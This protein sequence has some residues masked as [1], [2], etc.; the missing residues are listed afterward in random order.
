MCTVSLYG[1]FS[2]IRYTCQETVRSWSHAWHANS[3]SQMTNDSVSMQAKEGH[4]A[5]NPAH[6]QQPGISRDPSLVQGVTLLQ[7]PA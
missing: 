2:M 3:P 4:I 7:E 5:C 6:S 1:G